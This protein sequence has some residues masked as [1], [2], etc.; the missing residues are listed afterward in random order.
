MD[1]LHRETIL[2]LPGGEERNHELHLGLSAHPLPRGG[3]AQGALLWEDWRAPTLGGPVGGGG[4][5]VMVL[6][7]PGPAVHQ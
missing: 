6:L 7:V 2:H 5:M 1:R 3:E 4:Q